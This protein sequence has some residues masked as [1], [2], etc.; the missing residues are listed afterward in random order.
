MPIVNYAADI[1][2]TIYLVEPF[3]G[4]YSLKDKYMNGDQMV[5]SVARVTNL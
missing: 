2:C 5:N 3:S 1:E 4:F